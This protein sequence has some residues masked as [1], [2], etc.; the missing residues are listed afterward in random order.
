LEFQ[1]STFMIALRNLSKREARTKENTG[2]PIDFLEAFFNLQLKDRLM[3]D[4][5]NQ[6]SRLARRAVLAG[7][8]VGVMAGAT[9][10][11]NTLNP[12][13]LAGRANP[14]GR[15]A[16]K[17][18]LITGA[19]SG[20][21]RT[22]AEAFAREGARVAFCG[23]R[24]EL[25]R[26]VE[27]GIRAA[28]GDARYIR[29]D[30][31]IES[32]IADFVAAAVAAQGG[33]DICFNNAGYFAPPGGIDAVGG[34]HFDDSIATNLAG[35]Y[36]AMK[37]ELPHL[38]RNEAGVII[39]TASVAGNRGFG[40]TPFYSASKWG[41]I[42]LTKAVAVANARHNIRI[43]SISPLAV[44]TPMLRASFE[45]QKLTYEQ[46]APSFVTPRIMT[47]DEMAR[48]VMFAASDEA[49]SLTALDLDVTGGQL[50]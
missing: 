18:V 21:G 4:V 43:L 29:A 50:A 25:G 36:Y 9:A 24:E 5:E 44:D 41:L 32:Q 15:F 12:V 2:D 14:Q 27:A 48:A 31:R 23:R 16:G 49:T 47:T 11:A 7:A 45:A 20:I 37:H 40:H 10:H 19:T 1:S 17:S 46:V 33:L 38:R 42:G 30:V 22:T 26:E 35:V 28:G 39:N 8:V 34:E 13:A 3:N 6:Q